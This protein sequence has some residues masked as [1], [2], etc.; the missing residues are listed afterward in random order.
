MSC[1]ISFA[2]V[3]AALLLSGCVLP[4]ASHSD[5]VAL[6]KIKA[7][8]RLA[9]KNPELAIAGYI[10]MDPR[11]AIVTMINSGGSGAGHGVDKKDNADVEIDKTTDAVA[12]EDLEAEFEEWKKSG[13]EISGE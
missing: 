13:L 9:D 2:A 11:G 8:D 4:V 10:A 6:E 5:K 12:E 7:I 1:K 3:F